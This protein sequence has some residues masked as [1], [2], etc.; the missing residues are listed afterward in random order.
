MRSNDYNGVT[1]ALSNSMSKPAAAAIVTCQLHTGRFCAVLSTLLLLPLATQAANPD[2]SLR[3]SDSVDVRR[4]GKVSEDERAVLRMEWRAGLAGVDETR[5]VQDML[6]KLQRLEAGIS[7]ASRLIRDMPVQNSG[8]AAA[9]AAGA[10][11]ASELDWRLTVANIV[12]LVLVALWWFRRRKPGARPGTAPAAASMDSAAGAPELPSVATQLPAV[13]TP[14]QLDDDAARSEPVAHDE[15][16]NEAPDAAPH[17][18]PD[19]E[20]PAATEPVV[21]A[22]IAPPETKPA[23]A[24]SPDQTMVFDFSLEDADPE[25][26]A[27]ENARLQATAPISA[28]KPAP[29]PQ[30]TSV[31]PTLQLAEIMLSMGLEQGAAQALTEYIEANP[32]HAVYHWLKLLGIYRRRGLQKEFAE[33]AEKLRT[34]FNIQAEDWI[35]ADSNELPTLE[36]FSRVS[37][38]VQKIWSQPVECS[39]YLQR[40][41]ED[42]REGARA[43]FP[44]SVAEE[45][46][47]LLETL[48][49]SQA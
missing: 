33:T 24:F 30:E 21:T 5:S 36:K 7:A 38:H 40:L 43:G 35:K 2:P 1:I 46:L 45:I 3:R 41:L 22:S 14:A 10:P 34:H 29:A 9:V 42:N 11:D 32:R 4:L 12:A 6:D 23:E 47:F 49:E 17:L 8:T 16:H 25:T 39:S 44:Q 15:A 48:K 31:E 18:A 13:L 19:P 37:E 26:V 27:R 20:P 28:P